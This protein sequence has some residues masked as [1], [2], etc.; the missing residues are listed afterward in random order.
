[1]KIAIDARELQGK[2]TGVG[3]LLGKLL[4]EW[5]RMP[6]AQAHEFIQL[7]PAEQRPRGGTL[8]EQLVLPRVARHAAADVLFAPAYSGPVF[9]SIPMVVAIHDVSFAAHP[10]WFTWREGLRRRT[11]ARLAARAADRVVT[12]SEFSKREIVAHLG[13]EPSKIAVAYPGVTPFTGPK[14]ANTQGS[15]HT[16]TVLFVGSIFNRRHVPELIEGFA[17]VARSRPEMQLELVGDNRTTPRIN[18]DALVQATGIADRIHLRSYVADHE[19]PQLYAD[20]SAFVF[21]SEYEGFGLTPLE[22]IASGLPL[23]LLD[24][25]VAREVCADAAIYVPRPDAALIAD[26]LHAVLF[27]P[28]ERNRMLQAATE[29]LRRYSWTTFAEQVL[30]L[31]T[32]AGS[33]GAKGSAPRRLDDEPAVRDSTRRSR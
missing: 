2:P 31:L 10:E 25:P 24:T 22:A 4:E 1:M 9:S 13:V 15:P 20:A 33:R 3:R 14:G 27:E 7:A 12:I 18:L 17:I 32:D 8:W 29:V 30:S 21:L 23:V 28:G 16:C 11:T 6:A 19:L 5:S 26:A